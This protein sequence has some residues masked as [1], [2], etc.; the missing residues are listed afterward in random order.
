MSQSLHEHDDEDD[1]EF[2]NDI[3]LIDDVNA[4]WVTPSITEP[5]SASTTAEEARE[6][7]LLESANHIC[8]AR[9]QRALYQEHVASAVSDATAG[10]SVSFNCF[11]TL[12]ACRQLFYRCSLHLPLIPLLDIPLFEIHR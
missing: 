2:I 6:Q 11:F 9:A 8:M 10:K 5:E 3:T 7:L 1:V 4:E 12:P